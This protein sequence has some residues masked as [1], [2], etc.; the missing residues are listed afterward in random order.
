MPLHANEADDVAACAGVIVGN[1]IADLQQGNESRFSEAV[2]LGLSA[3]I[4]YIKKAQ[5]P[6]DEILILDQIMS[7]N[8]GSITEYNSDAYERIISCS[9]FIGNILLKNPE[10]YLE[11]KGFILALIEKRKALLKRAATS[12]R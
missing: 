12:G 11:N 3:Y 10:L 9:Q 2:D 7:A 5:T 4:T 8:V 1:A 6:I